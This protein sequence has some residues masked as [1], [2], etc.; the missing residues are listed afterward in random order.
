M[1]LRLHLHL[2]SDSTGETVTTVAR[3]AVSQFED[4][5]PVEHVWFFVRTRAQLEKVLSIIGMMPGMVIFTLISPD[6]R[7]LLQ[8]RCEQMN[9][10]CVPVLDAVMNSL[11]QM[12]GSS[13]MPKIGKQH[14]M[15]AGYFSRIAAMDFAMRH[16]DGQAP[17]RL[18]DADVVL[19]GVSRTS[20][21][22]TCVYLANRGIKAANVPIVPDMP[23]L[24]YLEKLKRPLIVGL[25]INAE[26]LTSIRR[27]RQKHMGVGDEGQFGGDYAEADRVREELVTA[28]RMFS[29]FGWPE[30]DVTRRSVEE[31]AAAVLQLL[32]D[33]REP[34]LVNEIRA[35]IAAADWLQDGD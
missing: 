6:L 20:K 11:T 30:I 27:N 5:V 13:G 10:P 19:V 22:P 29:K 35:P 23:Q 25:T 8:E 34:G 16:D 1:T 3:A 9:V 32:Q 28:R 24:R 26:H 31:T 14:E 33:R 15:D 18:D 21:T 17:E 7:Q 4:V 2:I 12:V